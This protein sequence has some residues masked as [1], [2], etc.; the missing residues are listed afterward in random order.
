M[1][2]RLDVM[3]RG[4]VL[5]T[6]P[7]VTRSTRN[8]RL[9]LGV[10]SAAPELFMDRPSLNLVGLSWKAN[11]HDIEGMKAEKESLRH[12][13][14]RAEF[15]ILAN[16]SSDLMRLTEAGF[17]AIVANANMFI[18]DEVF[19]PLD[20][21]GDT[22]PVAEAI[23]VAKFRPFKQ[24]HLCAGLDSVAF[25]Y[26]KSD[27][28][29]VDCEADVRRMFP[30]ARYLNH[31]AGNGAFRLLSGAQVATYL[32]RVA[33]GLCLSSEEGQMRASMEYLLCGLPVVTVPSRGGR[34]RYLLP[35]FTVTCEPEP[36]AIA[37]AVRD[38]KARGL[39]RWTIRERVATILAFERRNFL[40]DLNMLVERVHGVPRFFENLDPI[41]REPYW[42]R[43]PREIVEPLIRS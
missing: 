12:V 43:S 17:A 10:V 41:I 2:S 5:S 11:G 6:K 24:H 36:L 13:A 22:A 37:R 39:S 25:I 33:V 9:P 20:L 34:D 40:N 27:D 8:P 16:D 23:Y 32:N 18:D 26:H 28:G 14:P 3:M 42:E 35:E 29:G 19:R 38:V 4:Q 7:L 1:M 21:P 30:R 31:E 15:V